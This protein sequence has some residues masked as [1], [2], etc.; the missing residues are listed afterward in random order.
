[1]TSQAL[2]EICLAWPPA[3]LCPSLIPWASWSQNFLFFLF[4]FL[5]LFLELLVL[6]RNDS[7]TLVL[8]K[9]GPATTIQVFLREG[10]RSQAVILPTVFHTLPRQDTGFPAPCSVQRTQEHTV[11]A[12]P[13]EEMS[14]EC[15][16]VSGSRGHFIILNIFC[17]FSGNICDL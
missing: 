14:V 2:S 16:C 13:R 1:M 5:F 11:P 8:R 10:L 9:S 15:S 12:F 3:S 4:C 7:F 6:W 17:C